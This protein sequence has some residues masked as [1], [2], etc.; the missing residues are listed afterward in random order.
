MKRAIWLAVGGVCRYHG[1]KRA[2]APTAARDPN[3][4]VETTAQE[5]G[6]GAAPLWNLS[7]GGLINV[8]KGRGSDPGSSVMPS[9]HPI[10]DESRRSGD[11][12]DS[13]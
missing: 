5:V 9:A 4:R 3:V 12:E 2:G 8:Y 7:S 6:R 11:L 1:G 10:G 13:V